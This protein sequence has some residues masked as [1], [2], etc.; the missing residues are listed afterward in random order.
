MVVGEKGSDINQEGF[1]IS[2]FY[3][4]ILILLESKKDVLMDFNQVYKMI[5]IRG[6]NPKR[7]QGSQIVPNMHASFSIF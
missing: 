3:P 1:P 5:R 2:S 6:N 7:T 4:P